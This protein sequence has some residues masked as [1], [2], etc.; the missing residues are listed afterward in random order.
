MKK[1]KI[2]KHYVSE[3]D[4]RLAELFRTLP[5]SASQIAEIKK[6][7]R[8]YRLRDDANASK[9]EQRSDLWD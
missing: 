4:K 5:K 8:I 6:H 9:D 7:D 1:Q 2:D 3:A